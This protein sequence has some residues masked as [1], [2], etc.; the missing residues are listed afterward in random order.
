[1]KA[2][3]PFVHIVPAAVFLLALLTAAGCGSPQEVAPPLAGAPAAPKEERPPLFTFGI[4]YPMAHPFYEEIT[5]LAEKAAEPFSIQLIVKAP[6]EI[7]LEQQIR[8]M[9]TMIKQRVDAIAIDPI[10]SR[11]LVPVINKAVEAGIPVICFEADSP[12]SKRLSYI[13]TDHFQAGTAMGGVIER[14]LKG[15]GMLLVQTGLAG[16][17]IQQARL[18]GLLLYLEKHTD[19]QVMEVR[20]HEGSSEQALADMEAMIDDHPHFDALV[21]MDIISGSTSVLVWKAKGLNR[22][23][24]AF[25]LTP[26]IKE[27]V[28]NGQIASVISQN[29]QDWEHLLIEPLLK[30]T[31]KIAVP[32][33]VDTGI[34]EIKKE[35]QAVAR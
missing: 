2:A 12:D 4:V 9:E 14:L 23:A 26:E 8:M 6:E 25:G 32:A 1:M 5:Q 21:S 11:A 27:A 19:I 30:A 35:K 17:E 24:V 10:D 34:Q 29:E 33:F 3:I 18:E 20:Y 31:Q 16:M 15:R 28:H 22:D 13:G 7:N